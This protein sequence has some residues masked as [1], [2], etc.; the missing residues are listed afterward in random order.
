M[1]LLW[2]YVILR[3]VARL[4]RAGDTRAAGEQLDQDLDSAAEGAKGCVRGCCG[5][6]LAWIVMCLVYGLLY[7]ICDL[8]HIMISGR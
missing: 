5:C 1:A 3:W 8:I 7:A 2:W 4:L 6:Y